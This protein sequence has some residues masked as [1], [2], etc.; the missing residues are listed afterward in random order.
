MKKVILI[1]QLVVAQSFFGGEILY[2][3]KQGEEI[4]PFVNQIV[5]LCT[6]VYS[7]YPYLYDGNSEQDEY[8]TY[9]AGYAGSEK[10]IAALAFDGSRLIGAA[11]GKP[12]AEKTGGYI[13][14]LIPSEI[15]SSFYLGELV[16]DSAFRGM[17]IGTRLYHDFEE[18]VNN[19]E[20]YSLIWFAEIDAEKVAVAP[21]AGYVGNDLFWQALG[22]QKKECLFFTVPWLNVGDFQDSEHTLYYWS[23]A[24]KR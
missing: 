18:R 10:G 6:S 7:E 22:F 15:P 12:M 1:F 5:T 19:F 14:S 16:I 2:E 23:L 3:T 9:L 8:A 4:F 24:L 13:K 17:G 11:L 20:S 21:P